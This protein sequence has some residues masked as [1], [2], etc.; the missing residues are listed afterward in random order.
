VKNSHLGARSGI[1]PSAA[2]LG[3]DRFELLH[4]HW[5]HRQSSRSIAGL[6]FGFSHSSP[7]DTLQ[8]GTTRPSTT[9][10]FTGEAA[11]SAPLESD[12]ALSRFS[13]SGWMRTFPERRNNWQ[14][15]FNLGFDLE[16]SLATVEERV[17]QS[18]QL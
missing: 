11:G 8:R 5:R 3:N 4:G 12:A 17:F 6:S 13:L 15:H 18:V 1:E 2:L 14:H 16:E 7:T 9:R 10:L